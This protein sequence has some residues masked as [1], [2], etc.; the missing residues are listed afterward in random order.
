MRAYDYD[1]VP[2]IWAQA[3]YSSLDRVSA[4]RGTQKWPSLCG[5]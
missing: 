5:S 3:Q 2:C 1:G 4:P